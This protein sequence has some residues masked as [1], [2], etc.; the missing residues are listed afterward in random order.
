M[1]KNDQA[2]NL[3]LYFQRQGEGARLL[4]HSASLPAIG[5]PE[6]LALVQQATRDAD[7]AHALAKNNIPSLYM[8]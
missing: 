1:D 3:A 4:L 5:S 2:L 6:E 8:K 7:A